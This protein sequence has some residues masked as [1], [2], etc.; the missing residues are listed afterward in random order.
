VLVEELAV[1]LEG[2][3][4]DLTTAAPEPNLFK[5]P[6]PLGGPDVAVCL[7]PYSADTV[8][9][10]GESLSA[11]AMETHTFK[12]IARAPAG[13]GKLARTKAYDVYLKLRRLGPVTLSGV[14]YKNIKAAP[15]VFLSLDEQ[16]RPRFHFDATAWK[17]E[18][19]S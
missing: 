15:P 13:E 6:F 17:A 3:G 9:T 12:V 18:S 10:F 14:A 16:S 4:L 8:E 2:A 5:E 1:Y 11:P 19:P 7:I